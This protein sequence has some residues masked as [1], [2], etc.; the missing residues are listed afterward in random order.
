MKIGKISTLVLVMVLW[1]NPLW[2][3]SVQ[4]LSREVD[5][6]RED[7]QVLQRQTY[8][9]K[10][11][12]DIPTATTSSVQQQ[13]S[14]FDEKMRDI[15]GRMD[16]LE[17]KFKQVDER[18]KMLNQD[19][20][21]RFNLLEGKPINSSGV[22]IS[23]PAKRYDAPVAKGA[24]KS[25]AGE[26]ITG[27]D[28]APLPQV[29]KPVAAP[30][31]SIAPQAKL[32][33]NETYQAG[34]DAFNAKDYTKAEQNFSIILKDY[35]KDK[36]AGNAQYWIGEVY[37]NREDY[38]K[39]AVAFGKSYKNYKTGNKGPESLY[40]LGMSM[41]KLNKNAEAC[42]AYKSFPAEFPKADAA[43]KEKVKKVSVAA[44]CK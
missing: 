30:V 44:A 38:A 19:I 28:L 14:Q 24:P 8:R 37:Y 22:G 26:S 32:G 34:M 3:Q 1:G 41:Q 42:A 5:N 31:A 18:F 11:Q 39:A 40:K 23:A 13:L 17:Y 43:M 20:D 25:I 7:I 16:E 9:E 33:V 29:D 15:V 10:A 12:N 4:S 36:L 6:L 2:A 21:V 27:E 35:P